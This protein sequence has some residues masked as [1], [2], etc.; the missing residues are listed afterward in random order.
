MNNPVEFIVAGRSA[1]RNGFGLYRYLFVNR[2]GNSFFAFKSDMFKINSV[3]TVPG[4]DFSRL[5]F[6]A[7][8]Q[9][10]EKMPLETLKRC[11]DRQGQPEPK[12]KRQRKAVKRP[13]VTELMAWEDNQLDEQGMIDLFQRLIDT[14][15]AWTLQGMYGRQAARLIEAG[16]CHR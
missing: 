2:A 16:L 10:G 11:W 12:L 5:G 1:Q 15:M 13:S 14:G 3:I 8:N 4:A 6:E 9:V 7:V